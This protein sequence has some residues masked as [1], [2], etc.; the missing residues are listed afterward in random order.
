VLP[1][2]SAWIL[3]HVLLNMDVDR[4]EVYTLAWPTSREE[5]WKK[6]LLEARTQHKHSEEPAFV[7]EDVAV[8]ESRLILRSERSRVCDVL[9]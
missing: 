4:R 7:L 9:E 5:E 3:D 6:Y 8:S 1:A 2:S